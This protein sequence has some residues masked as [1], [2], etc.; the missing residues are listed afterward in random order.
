MKG[1]KKPIKEETNLN[2]DRE[3]ISLHNQLLQGIFTEI[4]NSGKNINYSEYQPDT[5]DLGQHQFRSVT[6]DNDNLFFSW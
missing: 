2:L 1:L 6:A 3:K 4:I 5:S